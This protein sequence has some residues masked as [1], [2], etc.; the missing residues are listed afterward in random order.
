MSERIRLNNVR[1]SYLNVF[2]ARAMSAE[3]DPKFSAQIILPKDHKQLKEFNTKVLKVAKEKFPKI[4]TGNKIPSKLKTPLRD[5]D[6]EYEEDKDLEVYGGCYFF[7]SN[8]RQRPTTLNRDKSQIVEE[9]NILY[10]GCYCN[11]IVDLFGYDTSGN[12]GVAAALMG[13]QFVRDGDALGGRG[14]SADDFDEVE[15]EEDDIDDII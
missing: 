12:K 8:N 7:N 2:K 4:V 11:V 14:V 3:Q 5:G 15:N 9:D 13:V 6:E 1:V 10:S